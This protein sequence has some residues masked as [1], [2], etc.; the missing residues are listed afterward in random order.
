MVASAGSV[1]L[2]SRAR[3]QST[4]RQFASDGL[5]LVKK[6]PQVLGRVCYPALVLQV[7]GYWMVSVLGR[8]F[9][10]GFGGILGHSSFLQL[11]GGTLCP[12]LVSHVPPNMAKLK[13]ICPL[14]VA[15][16]I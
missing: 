16:G 14:L 13:H 9:L 8:R 1:V 4:R 7:G 6:C 10:S 12:L 5:A 3:F 2:P 15:N 11:W